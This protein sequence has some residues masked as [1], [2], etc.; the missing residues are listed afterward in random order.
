M[1][2]KH[3]WEAK[4]LLDKASADNAEAWKDFGGGGTDL[5]AN[6]VPTEGGTD[7]FSTGGAYERI[8]V[9]FEESFS[10]DGNSSSISRSMPNANN[11]QSSLQFLLGGGGGSTDAT[12]FAVR[13]GESGQ[14]TEPPEARL[15]GRF[16]PEA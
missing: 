16:P 12:S 9:D 7:A 2:V 3:V 6:D 14:S 10:E 1:Q 11:R 8:I 13:F 5:V 15:Y 4:Q